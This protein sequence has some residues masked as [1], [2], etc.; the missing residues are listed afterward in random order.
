[1]ENNT[2]PS[3]DDS[4]LNRDTVLDSSKTSNVM[5]LEPY[6]PTL[7]D[8]DTRSRIRRTGKGNSGKIEITPGKFEP[9]NYAKFLILE[10]REGQQMRDLDMFSV[11]REIKMKCS[12]EP[13]ISYMNDGSLLV[14]VASPDDSTKVQNISSLHGQEIDCL[15]NKR[16]NQVKGVIRSTELLGYSEEKIQMELKDQGVVD[17]KQMK[18]NI[19]GV[20]T[21]L[22]TY[23]LTF[24]LLKLPNMI[25][26]AWL[27]LNV[28]PYIPSCRRC[29]YCQKFG[30][31]IGTCRRKIKGENAVCENCGLEAHGECSNSPHCIN[32]GEDH[33]ASSKK[34]DKF[35]F[36]K[37]V[38]IL[39]AKEHLSFKE[40]RQ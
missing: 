31:V 18:K 14:E 35:T 29:F 16:L 17:V 12:I 4:G 22:P 10:M 15:Y 30:H 38:Q 11:N 8:T 25:M 27:R 20:L 33:P 23:V 2:P 40:A 28:R 39:R 24:D 13:K 36:E 5:T 21:P 32:C 34:C 3:V 6:F 37:E 26:A 9:N 7:S 1:M 19:G